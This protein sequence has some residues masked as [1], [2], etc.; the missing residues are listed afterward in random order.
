LRWPT[1]APSSS[2]EREGIR[3]PR[4]RDGRWTI[5]ADALLTSATLVAVRPCARRT[6]RTAAVACARDLGRNHMT[7]KITSEL[8]ELKVLTSL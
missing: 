4:A 8:G 6:T 3:K 7:G 5:G 1:V 2:S